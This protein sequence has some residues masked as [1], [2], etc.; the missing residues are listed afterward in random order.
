[1]TFDIK[2]VDVIIKD[3]GKVLTIAFQTPKARDYVKNNPTFS[4]FTYLKVES[5]EPEILYF[6]M[7]KSARQVLK[8]MLASNG[9]TYFEF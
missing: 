3:E 1:M 6:D 2:L 8:G 5:D 7:K 4:P 9:L